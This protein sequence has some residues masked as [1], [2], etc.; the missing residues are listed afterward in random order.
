M[1]RGGGGGHLGKA[2]VCISESGQSLRETEGGWVPAHDGGWGDGH[3]NKSRSQGSSLAGTQ[4]SRGGALLLRGRSPWSF[5][6]QDLAKA[7]YCG[8]ELNEGAQSLCVIFPRQQRGQGR[9]GRRERS[10]DCPSPGAELLRA[11]PPGS[12]PQHTCPAPAN[13]LRCPPRVCSPPEALVP[14]AA[15]TIILGHTASI[16]LLL[17]SW[18]GAWPAVADGL[19]PRPPASL[20]LWIPSSFC[21][22]G[23]PLGSTPALFPAP[24][25][26]SRDSA[27]RLQGGPGIS[28]GGPHFF[29]ISPSLLIILGGRRGGLGLEASPPLTWAMR[30]RHSRTERSSRLWDQLP[31]NQRESLQDSILSPFKCRSILIAISFFCSKLLRHCEVSQ[32]G[33]TLQPGKAVGQLAPARVRPL[34]PGFPEHP[35]RLKSRVSPRLTKPSVASQQHAEGGARRPARRHASEGLCASVSSSVHPRML[36]RR[37]RGPGSATSWGHT[38]HRGRPKLGRIKMNR[39]SL[40]AGPAQPVS[41]LERELLL[42]LVPRVEQLACE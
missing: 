15:H 25:N 16:S 5:R 18:R 37:Y 20:P 30:S 17:S 1:E 29:L 40:S 14:P 4:A 35:H 42:Q 34:T 36:W 22:S 19:R 8:E 32:E 12:S 23:A 27:Q 10:G 7:L 9:G 13:S 38:P 41:N 31:S 3:L 11:E 33:Y 26:P 24:G 39:H 28:S 6:A 2:G 21:L